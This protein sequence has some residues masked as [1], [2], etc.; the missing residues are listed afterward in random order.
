LQL[1][2]LFK[3]RSAVHTCEK[4]DHKFVAWSRAPFAAHSSL[5]ST[6]WWNVTGVKCE[7]LSS[8]F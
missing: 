2:P 4:Q 7:K 5:V 3:I 6:I 8:V 1:C